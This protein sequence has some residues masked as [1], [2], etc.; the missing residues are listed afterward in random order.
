MHVVRKVVSLLLTGVTS[1]ML[2]AACHGSSSTTT[3]T[4]P[5]TATFTYAQAAPSTPLSLNFN[6]T[7]SKSADG[8]TPTYTWS[9]GDQIPSTSTQVLTGVTVNHIYAQPGT[10]VVSLTVTD[11]HATSAVQI[12]KI[13]VTGTPSILMGV[14]NWTWVTGSQYA[15][16]VGGYVSQ[17]SPNVNNQPSARQNGATWVHGMNGVAD[18]GGKMWLF[19]GGGND[20]T[21]S[22]GLLND[23]WYFTPATSAS[24]CGAVTNS[25]GALTSGVTSGCWTWVAGS[26]RGNAEGIYPPTSTNYPDSSTPFIVTNFPGARTAPAAWTDAGGNFWMFGGNGYD[27]AAALGNL[28]D[29]WKFN[30]ATGQANWV[31]GS[32]LINDQ[33]ATN[34]PRARSFATTWTTYDST[35]TVATFWLFGGQSLDS[36]NTTSVQLNDLWS[37]NPST[38]VWTFVAG[39]TSAATIAGNYGTKGTAALTN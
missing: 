35:H 7:G 34:L 38:N 8:V 22:S 16:S 29:M 6:A 23:L 3:S 1:A 39:S 14:E 33:G 30:G 5:P 20:S 25:S 24:S 9:F 15:N 4:T 27:S 26:N 13:T 32:K 17:F 2:L 12:Q 11:D 21:G 19:G 36:A 28:N 37:F 10:Y 18:V 31:A